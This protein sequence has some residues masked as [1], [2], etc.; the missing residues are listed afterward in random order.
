MLLMFLFVSCDDEFASNEGTVTF[1]TNRPATNGIDIFIEGTL[2]GSL[3]TFFAYETP[4]CN[5]GGTL[6]LDLPPGIYNYI[7][8]QPSLY[9]WNGSFNIERN[10]CTRELLD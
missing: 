6:S 5:E 3:T 7:A 2:E 10:T 4:N 9:Q 8:V 1:W